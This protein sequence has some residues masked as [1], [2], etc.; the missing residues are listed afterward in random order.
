[1]WRNGHEV[2]GS[3]AWVSVTRGGG[4]PRRGWEPVLDADDTRRARVRIAAITSRLAGAVGVPCDLAD[5][6]AGRAVLAATLDQAGIDHPLRAAGELR[7]A[8]AA[9]A[10]TPLENGLWQGLGGIMWASAYL[11]AGP[12]TTRSADAHLLGVLERAT[13][14]SEFDLIRGVVGIGVYAL[15]RLDH[16]HGRRM[17]GLAVDHLA[18]TIEPADQPLSWRRPM[19]FDELPWEWDTG[20]AHGVAGAI[21]LLT[22]AA[23]RGV[24][25][26][27]ANRL[28]DES[29]PRLIRL[30]DPTG[31]SAAFPSFTD[32]DARAPRQIGWCR[33]DL[34]IATA[35]HHAA[36]ARRRDDW[37]DAVREVLH[38]AARITP[39]RRPP[40]DSSLCHGSAG[41]GVIFHR[42]FQATGDPVYA[43]AARAWYRHALDQS[44]PEDPGMLTGAVGVALALTAAATAT[45]PSWDRALLISTVAR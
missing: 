43:D 31:I 2:I 15:E 6:H 35:L 13:A 42:H 37:R 24:H 40:R 36:V 10:T 34:G 17:L 22:R 21:A 7:A 44:V 29:V 23:A 32:P 1:M 3:G 41:N 33:G 30:A 9:A 18:A 8:R 39:E 19:R 25:A 45:P 5:G 26:E 27:V 11:G 28:I 16:E 14:S 38:A 20:M 12:Q 4:E